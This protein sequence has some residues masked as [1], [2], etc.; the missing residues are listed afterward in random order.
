MVT[1]LFDIDGT[2][3]QT[4]GAGLTAIH[5]AMRSLFEVDQT[6]QVTVHG[7]TDHGILSDIFAFHDKDYVEHREEFNQAYW[8]RLPRTLRETSGSVLPGV[9]TLLDHLEQRDDV[10]MGL[11]T[12]NA[13]QA[14]M[15]K[16][17]HFGLERY[18][19]FGGYGD[20]H[21]DRNEVARLA[22][23]E[24]ARFN[25]DRFRPDQVWVIGDTVNDIVCARAVN[26]QVVAVQT[27][28]A[29]PQALAQAQP[30]VLMRDLANLDEFLANVVDCA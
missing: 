18:F 27:G 17:Q 12:G 16:L 19:S 25:G 3:I 26:A 7:R 1:I 8:E 9:K 10:A 20:L 13:H 5:Q 28:G 22:V 15:L 24:A 14:A 6:P 21:A 23:N 2:L 11:L 30:D 4:A 29:D